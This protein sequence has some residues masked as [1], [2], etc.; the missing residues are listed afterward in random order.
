MDIF[1]V[2]L[3]ASGRNVTGVYDHLLSSSEYQETSSPNPETE[4]PYEVH[5]IVN[6]VGLVYLGNRVS[7]K[8]ALRM[9]GT[10]LEL[11]TS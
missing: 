10:G 2:I 8:K 11:R 7:G 4:L 1:V 6:W 3:Q 5:S 9:P